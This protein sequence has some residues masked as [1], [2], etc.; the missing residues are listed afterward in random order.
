MHVEGKMKDNARARED[1]KIY[2]RRK[3]LEKNESTSKY[4]KACYNLGPQEKTKLF[5]IG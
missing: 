1:I 2:Y 5:V 4:P 3:E